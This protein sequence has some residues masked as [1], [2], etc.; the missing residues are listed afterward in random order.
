[1]GKV[2]KIQIANRVIKTVSQKADRAI[3]FYSC[4][5]DSLALL[6]LMAPHFKEII[7]VFMYFAKDL[8][9]IN[10]YIRWAESKYPNI[11]VLQVPHWNLTY[12]LRACLNFV[13]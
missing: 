6:D 9:H 1:M 10:R 12:I 8:E 4:G 13:E 3:L 11:K 5:K 2:S 7:C